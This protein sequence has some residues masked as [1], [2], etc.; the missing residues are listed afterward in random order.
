[1]E[2]L[3]AQPVGR[4]QVLASEFLATAGSLALAFIIGQGLPIALYYPD[5]LGL[6]YVFVSIGLSF[7]CAA[8]AFLAAVLSRDK[9]RGIGVVLLIWFYFAMIYDGIVLMILF[10]FSD[11]PLEKLTLLLTALNPIDLARVSMMLQMDV[12]ALMGYTGAL[13]KEFFG[14]AWGSLFTIGILILWIAFP[15]TWAGIVFRKKDL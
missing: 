14:S 10:A 8:I 9:A 15:L 5:G 1:M 6:H 12:S 13:F 11:Y 7:S 2:M 3:L 4:L